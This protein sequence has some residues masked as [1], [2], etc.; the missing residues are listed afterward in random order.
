MTHRLVFLTET[1]VADSNTVYHAP[2]GPLDPPLVCLLPAHALSRSQ[3]PF[4]VGLSHAS[5]ATH[6]LHSTQLY[7][8]LDS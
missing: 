5:L 6:P 4:R 2:I 1:A 7:V 8:R 3:L